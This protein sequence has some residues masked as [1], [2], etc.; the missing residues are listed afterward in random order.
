MKD[1]K[2]LVREFILNN[3]SLSGNEAYKKTVDK[4]F[5][6]RKTDFYKEFRKIKGLSEPSVQKRE[7]SVPTKYKITPKPSIPSKPK[8]IPFKDTKFGKIVDAVKK[9]HNISEQ[10]AI[11][12]SRKILKIPN[13]DRHKIHK[14]DRYILSQYKT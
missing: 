8:P 11:E 12:H 14:K 7:K 5:G 9:T 13:K 3:P 4:G 6:I 1:R 10:H 2:E